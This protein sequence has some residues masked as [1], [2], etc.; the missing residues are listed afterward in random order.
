MQGSGCRALDQRRHRREVA[1]LPGVR[2]DEITEAVKCRWALLHSGQ[3]CNFDEDDEP[4]DN[5]KA[6]FGS[7]RKQWTGATD[8]GRSQYLAVPG[9]SLSP[10]RVDEPTGELIAS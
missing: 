6:A 9:L 3:V 8:L 2:R 7:G 1:S 5:I 10:A 4:V